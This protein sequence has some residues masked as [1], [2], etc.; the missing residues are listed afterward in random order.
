MESMT[1]HGEKAEVKLEKKALE[2]H[3]NGKSVVPMVGFNC[4]LCQLFEA[5]AVM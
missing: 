4:C 1:E 5:G 2:P 3:E